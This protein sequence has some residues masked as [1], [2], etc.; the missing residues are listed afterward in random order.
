MATYKY[1][2]ATGTYVL[3]N[4]PFSVTTDY[5][6]YA[7]GSTAVFTATNV[8]LGGAVQF[9]VTIRVVQVQMASGVPPTMTSGA[10]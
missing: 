8:T 9:T 2:P 3:T 7:P 4:D 6:D 10:R 1:D 5:A